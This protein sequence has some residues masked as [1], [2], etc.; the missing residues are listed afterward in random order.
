[1][2]TTAGKLEMKDG[3]RLKRVDALYIDMQDKYT[4]VQSFGN[5]AMALAAVRIQEKNDIQTSRNING[6]KNEQP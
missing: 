4:F 6:I 1:M 2:I 3:E 5:G